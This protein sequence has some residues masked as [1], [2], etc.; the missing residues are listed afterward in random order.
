MYKLGQGS[1]G[2]SALILFSCYLLAS[3]NFMRRWLFY[4][5][6]SSFILAYFNLIKRS[7]SFVVDNTLQEYFAYFKFIS[8]DVKNLLREINGKKASKS[9]FC[10][11]R[12]CFQFIEGNFFFSYFWALSVSTSFNNLSTFFDSPRESLIWWLL[13][14][15]HQKGYGLGKT[16]LET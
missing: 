8:L 2:G 4:W 7:T 5:W 15:H 14:L 3:L 13:G 1:T 16:P 12:F 10:Q 9:N 6:K 11:W